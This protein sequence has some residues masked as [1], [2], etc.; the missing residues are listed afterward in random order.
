MFALSENEN[1]KTLV[2]VAFRGSA[3]STI[4]TLSYP[5][6]AILGK[7]QKKYVVILSHTQRQV[8]Q[9]LANLK[10][11]LE[12]N[13]LL[14]ADLGPFREET[15]QWGS[16][17]LVIP[18][19]KARITVASVEQSIRGLKH[20]EHRP[21]LIIC[22]DIEDLDSVRTK[23]SRDK[24][25]NWLTGDVIPAGDR[26]TRFIIVGNLLHGDSPLMR[27]KKAIK[28]KRL[29]GVYKEYPFLNEKGE[30]LWKS[31][32]P[33]QEAIEAEKRKIGDETA[34]QREFMLKIVADK[35]RVIHPDWISYYDELPDIDNE[36]NRYLYTATAVDLAISQKETANFTA[37]VSARVYGYGEKRRIYILPFPINKRLT[38]PETVEKAK[39]ISRNLGGGIPTKLFIEEV[40]YQKSLIQRLEEEGYPT[41][42]VS[43][44]GQDKRARLSIITPYLKQGKVLFPKKGAEVLIGQLLGFGSE[45]YDDLADAFAMLIGKIMEEDQYGCSPFPDQGNDPISRPLTAGWLD[46]EF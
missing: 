19:Y 22:D 35:D 10:K 21:D 7:Q 36:E 42:G 18:K 39:E 38:F 2:T 31:K 32:F 46:K 44:M 37:M 1:I 4:F 40:G 12:S 41:E 6:W 16:G 43:V 14:R 28:E 25:Y 17:S 13:N 15:D 34:W 24:T 23:E 29:D 45:K 3:K 11:E 8:H 9:H 33:N 30:A 26:D 27:I 20:G 5:I